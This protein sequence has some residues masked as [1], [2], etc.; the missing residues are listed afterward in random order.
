LYIELP[1][2]ENMLKHLIIFHSII[3]LN[4]MFLMQLID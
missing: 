1:K 2:K 3:L 4:L